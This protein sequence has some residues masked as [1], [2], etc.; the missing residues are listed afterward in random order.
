MAGPHIAWMA[1]VCISR[2]ERGERGILFHNWE[3]GPLQ[4]RLLK[5]KVR[6]VHYYKLKRPHIK[7][8]LLRCFSL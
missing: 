6:I 3:T 8:M 4:C 1:S 2:V 5:D 7:D